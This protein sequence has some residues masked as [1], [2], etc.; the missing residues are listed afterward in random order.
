MACERAKSE[1][2]RFLLLCRHR[3]VETSVAALVKVYLSQEVCLWGVEGP[4]GSYSASRGLLT[5]ICFKIQKWAT[6]SS[7]AQQ[8]QMNRLGMEGSKT[9]TCT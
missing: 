6:G 9:V 2:A 8:R 1:G 7:G 3:R 5:L 4:G